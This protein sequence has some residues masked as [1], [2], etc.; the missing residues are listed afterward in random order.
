MSSG[1]P[2]PA[3]GP[4]TAPAPPPSEEDRRRVADWVEEWREQMAVEATEAILAAVEGYRGRG[5]EADVARHCAQIFEVF[6][7]TI[8]E[9]REPVLADF[10]WTAGHAAKRVDSGVSLADFLKAFRVGQLALWRSLVY[11]A[12]EEQQP[13]EALLGFVDHVMLTV[14]V[15]S[16][17]A[18]TSYLEEQQYRVADRERLQRAVVEDL[19]SGLPPATAGRERVLRE[20]DIHADDTFIVVTATAA[21]TGA[22]DERVDALVTTARSGLAHAGPGLFVPRHNELVGIVTLRGRTV[23]E[24]IDALRSVRERIAGRGLPLSI[25]ISTSHVGLGAVREA[26]NE[27]VLARDSLD[28]RG[29]VVSIS[30]LSALNYLVRRPDATAQRLVRPEVHAFFAEDAAADGIYAE[31]LQAF[32]DHHLNAREAARAI[33]V[34]VNTVY[35]RLERIASRTHTDLRKIDELVE[36][37]LAIRAAAQEQ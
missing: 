7:T 3:H 32:A 26:Y 36:L 27:A 4:I 35:Y 30:S 15:G 16:T 37:L 33:H 8:R 13:L 21:G 23:A 9:G 19:L 18:A 20:A 25:G 2:R 10:P 22:D 31:T 34:H 12:R 17:A 14:E 5:Q 29:G 6:A 11:Y 1:T 24:A 28:Q